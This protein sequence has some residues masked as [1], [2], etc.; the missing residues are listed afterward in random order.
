MQRQAR[1]LALGLFM[2]AG[3]VALATAIERGASR[4]QAGQGLP[5]VMLS[6][7]PQQP[8]CADTPPP[9]VARGTIDLA[10]P[11]AEITI[12]LREA[13]D[14]PV[15]FTQIDLRTGMRY[16]YGF[17]IAD[18]DCDSKPDI[19]MFDSYVWT[20]RFLNP[21]RGAI[22]FVQ[23]N[24][25]AAPREI[26]RADDY[27]EIGDRGNG[28][29]LFERHIAF[30]VNGDGY[31]D[32]V[33]VLNS[34]ASVVA[35]IN[36]GFRGR[37]WRRQYLST[38]IPG[39][40]N[41]ASGDIDG[42]GLPDLVISMRDQ[43]STDPNPAIRGIVWLRNPGGAGAW[44]QRT[45]EDSNGLIDPRTLA[46]TDID[47]DGLLDIVASDNRLGRLMWW[48]NPGATGEWVSRVIP[49]V[50]AGDGMFGEVRDFDGDGRPDILQPV[51]QGVVIARNVDGG[52]NWQV[53]P[54]ARF[55]FEPRNL[56]IASASSADIDLDGRT[57]ILV[58]VST[59]AITPTGRSRGGVYLFR[60][61]EDRWEASKIYEEDSSTIDA[62]PVDYLGNGRADIVVNSEYQRNGIS[63]FLNRP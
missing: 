38:S 19:S 45:V 20:R 30:D 29:I 27:P 50:F 33:G 2:A 22:G 24:G 17:A 31:L 59:Y 8:G 41:L 55:A 42:D 32:I 6:N 10:N 5:S 47:G 53:V 62:R 3:A 1:L 49:G 52:A 46:A 21:V 51:Y 26:V 54:V 18:F 7:L 11:P 14:P 44:E 4:L 9:D 57:D 39:A 28:L 43:P 40:I 61:T 56:V 34:H 15:P 37:T 35:Y 48:K 60:Q 63:L 13:P 12:D 23:W 16:A 36:P 58:T 25:E